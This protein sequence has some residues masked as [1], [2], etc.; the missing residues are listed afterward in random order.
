MLGVLVLIA[1]TLANSLSHTVFLTTSLLTT[2]LSLLKSARTVLILSTSK[3]STPIFKPAKSVSNPSLDVSMPVAP[4]GRLLLH[5]CIDTIQLS[6]FLQ[7]MVHMVEENID[8]FL[9]YILHINPAIKWII[10]ALLFD[11]HSIIFSLYY[12]L[13]EWLCQDQWLRTDNGKTNLTLSTLNKHLGQFKVDFSDNLNTEEVHLGKKDLNL[14]KEG[15]NRLDL[16]YFLKIQNLWWS[17][18]YLTNETYYKSYNLDKSFQD[19]LNNQ[20]N[21][22]NSISSSDYLNRQFNG[23]SYSTLHKSRKSNLFYSYYWS[24]KH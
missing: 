5:N 20:D 8:S 23:L 24:Y 14:N 19:N 2:L 6:H 10:V 1:L 11:V 13:A 17:V 9:Y 12:F 16:S 3:T 21:S 4:S 18:A 22:L 7:Q 15:K